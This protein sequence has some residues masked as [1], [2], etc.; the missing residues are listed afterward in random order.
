MVPYRHR[1]VEKYSRFMIDLISAPHQPCQV[2]FK[3]SPTCSNLPPPVS[4]HLNPLHVAWTRSTLFQPSSNSLQPLKPTFNNS[5]DPFLFLRSR[6]SS[7]RPRVATRFNI[8]Q[9]TLAPRQIFRKNMFCGAHAGRNKSSARYKFG[10][11][12]FYSVRSIAAAR[13][14]RR[15][16]NQP[17][18]PARRRNISAMSACEPTET[19]PDTKGRG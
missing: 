10:G 19:G 2:P 17:P 4:T 15:L 18:S 16:P 5:I 9:R 8:H 11:T 12:Y 13:F 7:I 14:R 1:K 6:K 3:F